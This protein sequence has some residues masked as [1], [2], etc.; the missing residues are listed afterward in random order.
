MD[1]YRLNKL[2][3]NSRY[4][5]FE[6]HFGK[7]IVVDRYDKSYR[8]R[9]YRKMCRAFV[10]FTRFNKLFFYKHFILTLS[11]PVF[12]ANLL[13]NFL[14]SLRRRYGRLCYIWTSE[15]QFER[16]KKYNEVAFHWHIIVGFPVGT[17]IN[18]DD[19]LR[20]Q[21]YWKHGALAV[22]SV[23]KL[24]LN[25]LLKYITKS[26]SCVSDFCFSIR[27]ISMSRIPLLFFHKFSD[28]IK[29]FKWSEY[30]LDRLFRFYRVDKKGVYYMYYDYLFKKWRKDYMLV[31]ND[32]R[33]VATYDA[34]PF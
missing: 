27:R 13:N 20:L 25:Y 7:K 18:S 19:I 26:F 9:R 21:R 28:I 23:K 16:F 15:I 32:W 6:N 8:Y 2:N 34:E 22:R 4:F 1:E 11:K 29:M 33:L 30:N 10:N 17:N 24:N 12:A 14:N 5:V 31:L 3:Y